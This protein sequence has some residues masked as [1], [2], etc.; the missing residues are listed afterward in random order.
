M[1]AARNSS[2]RRFL[3]PWLRHNRKVRELPTR[4]AALEPL[5][6]RRLLDV[7]GLGSTVEFRVADGTLDIVGTDGDDEL[8]FDAAFHGKVTA[9][10]TDYTYDPVEITELRFDGGLGADRVVLRGSTADDVVE[11]WPDH[12]TFS[13][14]GLSLVFAGIQ[15]LNVLA[16]EG[17][18]TFLLNDSLGDDKLVVTDQS[19]SFRGPNFSQ[20]FDRCDVVHA[21]GRSEGD[22]TAK[23][24]NSSGRVKFKSS[25]V[26]GK[27]YGNGCYAR[28]KFFE[29]VDAQ[30]SGG[31]D[32]ARLFDSAGDDAFFGSQNEGRMESEDFL[33][34]TH[35]FGQTLV[36]ASKGNDVAHLTDSPGDD[37]VRARSHKTQMYDT[38]TKGELYMLTVRRFDEVHGSATE[39]GEDIAK[40]HDTSGDDFL[41]ADGERTCLYTGETK[42]DLLYEM[43]AFERVKAYHTTGND[44]QQTTP[45][46]DYLLIEENDWTLTEGNLAP[47]L[48]KVEEN[49]K[50]STSRESLTISL[51]EASDPDDDDDV[52]AFSA[53]VLGDP[54]PGRVAVDG[55]DL[56]VTPNEGFTGHLSVSVTVSDGLASD[57]KTLHVEMDWVSA[58]LISNVLVIRGT[59]IEKW[60]DNITV[61]M[62]PVGDPIDPNSAQPG[63]VL[64]THMVNVEDHGKLIGSWDSFSVFRIEVTALAGDD[65]VNL[66]GIAYDSWVYGGPGDDILKG[67]SGADRLFGGEG[68]DE[69]VGNAGN[70]VLYGDAGKNDEL[71]GGPGNDYLSVSPRTPLETIPA[72]D[73]D[74]ETLSY[75]ERMYFNL[76]HRHR[77]AWGFI[78]NH[79]GIG[80]PDELG[81]AGIFTG[82][83][84][85][86]A[87]LRGNAEDTLSLLK[88]LRDEPWVVENGRTQLV[89]HPNVFDYVKENGQVVRDRIQPMTKDGIVGITAG[90]YYAYTEYVNQEDS[91]SIEI[92]DVATQLMDKYI[93]YL[94]ANQWKT[95][96]HYPDH[97]WAQTDY[98]NSDKSAFANVVTPEG[99]A[100]MWKGPEGYTLSPTDMFALQNSAA[101]M[102]FTTADWNPWVNFGTTVAQVLGDGLSSAFRA[103]TDALVDWVGEQ[104]DSML[105]QIKVDHDF[106]FYVIKDVEWTRVRGDLHIAISQADRENVVTFVQVEF[107]V[108]YAS[109]IPALLAQVDVLPELL[110]D[111]IVDAL[112]GWTAADVWKPVVNGTLQQIM[113]WLNGNSFGELIAF[114]LAFYMAKS[115]GVLSHL[116]FWPTLMMYETRPEM[117]DMLGPSVADLHGA[118]NGKMDMLLFA[119]LDRDTGKVAEWIEDFE[120]N[121]NYD[122]LDYA[123]KRPKEV[124]TEA[125]AEQIWGNAKDGISD[126]PPRIGHHR[127]DY[128][129][130][131]QLAHR[132]VPESLLGPIFTVRGL[133]S[134]EPESS[135]GVV[136]GGQELEQLDYGGV[137]GALSAADADWLDPWRDTLQNIGNQIKKAWDD[138]RKN[139]PEFVEAVWNEF[140]PTFSELAG[141]LWGNVTDD[142]PE[143]ASLLWGYAEN[144]LAKFAQ[145]LWDNGPQEFV[146]FA[147]V[148]WSYADND[149][150]KYAGALWDYAGNDLAKFAQA[151]WDNGP[152]EF[153]EFAGVLWSYADNDLTKYAGV[154]WDYA[155]NDL[156]GLAKALWDNGSQD[157]VELARIVWDYSGNDLAQYAAVLWSYSRNDLSRLAKAIR[158]N[159]PNDLL[160]L[161]NVLWNYADNDIV[162]YAGVL[163]VD[164][165]AN[166]RDIARALHSPD[167]ADL[168]IYDI[169]NV[170]WEDIT[171]DLSE[172]ASALW[173]NVTD[174]PVE[175]ANVL[176]SLVGDIDA[177]ANALSFAIDS[178]DSVADALWQSFKGVIELPELAN[179]LFTNWNGGFF[180][181]PDFAGA[182]SNQVNELGAVANALSSVL[183]N[184]D[185]VATALWKGFHGPRDLP[186]IA[187]AIW[188]HW[189]GASAIWLEDLAGALSEQVASLGAVADALSSVVDNVDTVAYALCSGYHGEFTASDLAHALW[190]N[191]SGATILLFKDLAGA[192]SNQWD[193]LGAVANA[194]SSVINNVDTVAKALCEGFHGTFY[195]KDLANALWWNWG[196]ASK[197]WFNDLAGAL[198]NHWPSLG[199]VA[200]AL[201]SVINNVD[202][203]AKALCEGFHGTFY[204]KDLANALWW[205]WG[206]AS[207]LWFNDLAGALSNHWPSLGA[208]ANALSSV[209]NNVD[210]VAKALCEGFHG[211]FYAKD[212]ANALWWNWGGA[213]GFNFRDLAGALSNEWTSL[214]TVAHAL[215][216]VI[217]NVY[218]V[219]DALWHGFHPYHYLYEV[220]G[221]MWYNWNGSVFYL[222]DLASALWNCGGLTYGNVAHALYH[223]ISGTSVTDV[224]WA[225]VDAFGLG[226]EQALSLVYGSI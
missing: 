65:A 195:A 44:T 125:I 113:P 28:A 97:Y 98:P 129:I 84:T 13:G 21:Y 51:K 41:V 23:F 74:I 182:L 176:R 108:D 120:S 35:S 207:K 211:T 105:Q 219:A 130:L 214:G 48:E 206:G 93:S 177:L 136:G 178:I 196:G 164:L 11:A 4:R 45:E 175:L 116:T 18:D 73:E 30:A 8:F 34:T 184:A 39:G 47:T 111:K 179:A 20:V 101:E 183:G 16:S 82:I 191:W 135:A 138:L 205:N 187:D 131:K 222:D 50:M 72:G 60:G 96:D 124:N 24:V 1:H 163:K 194:L 26:Y 19:V 2:I 10:G 147:G 216:S 200:N 69:L 192:L 139:L 102:G 126:D 46:V 38:D 127:L 118:L 36:Y 226:Y 42:S 144:D 100:V 107:R 15:S 203:V 54:A 32:L 77:D 158:D 67:G 31:N 171:S 121:P 150:A 132:G 56:I 85:A 166:V 156:V 212:L 114:N 61:T 137:A 40:L 122:N 202:T 59:D 128:L 79:G 3:K 70:D 62:V 168:G 174:D 103:A 151:L 210:T 12:G 201:S 223:G 190:W 170:L 199:A 25:P 193:N 33:V 52:L 162:K 148:L 81:D 87:A 218:S 220:A 88:T 90:A 68:K 221:A 71:N 208:V 66:E 142:F 63:Q 215:S 109:E 17:M 53:S 27:M 204:A 134:D 37:T 106:D 91:V 9:N 80:Q 154:L 94:I 149:L 180:S 161:A 152:Q 75:E 123:W 14:N 64:P 49:Y 22:D 58:E 5:E 78:I 145:A 173:D 86:T 6:E 225:L 76:I 141:A 29:V 117:V 110:A 181:F 143:Y 160:E 165:E 217:D 140:S 43:M 167:G 55:H 92:C 169:A 159:G 146:E 209:I 153:V 188:S 213:S 83:A 89:R 7:A 198:S 133:T 224:A 95:I 155:E 115:D 119:W 157:F 189:G 172:L 99:G 186:G 57:Q 104:V 185:W 112:P 197:L